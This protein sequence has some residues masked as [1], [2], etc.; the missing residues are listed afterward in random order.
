MSIVGEPTNWADLIDPLV[1]DILGLVIA[2]WE[3]MAAP[4][5]DAREDQISVNLCK[6]LQQNR[7]ARELFFQI[8]TQQVELNPAAGEDIG[9]MDISFRPLVAREDIYFCLECKRLNVI[10]DGRTRSYASEYVVFGVARFVSGQYASRVRH[11]GMLAYVLNGDAARAIVSVESNL[12]ERHA[13]LGMEPPGAFAP[14]SI[15]VGDAKVKET[16]HRRGHDAVLFCLHHMFMARVHA[17]MDSVA[18]L[19]STVN[20]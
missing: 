15:I 2:T 16:H 6:L 1:P 12:R 8:D 17:P 7:T 14:S 18:S 10:L 19:K 3:G 11:G 4:P 20:P 13:V 5:T 9:R